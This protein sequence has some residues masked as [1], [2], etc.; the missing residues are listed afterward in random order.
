VFTG[1]GMSAESGISTFRDSNGLWDNHKVEDV[2]SI[3]A[4]HRNSTL[5]L[6]FYN[7]RRRQLL[8]VKPNKGHEALVEMEKRFPKLRVITQNVD[9]LHERAGQANVLHLHGQ[10]RTSRSTG[11]GEEVFSIE[12]SELSLGD[13]CPKGFQLRP[14]IVWFGEM[15]PAFEEALT[16]VSQCDL[17]I[18]VGTSLAV[19][20]AASLLDY[21]GEQTDIL[22]IDP[23]EPSFRGPKPIYHYP[24]KAAQGLMELARLLMS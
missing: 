2:A 10:L 22:L 19:Y 12:G 15:V 11:P 18:V 4:W 9:D 21:V 5:V 8:E 24:A 14:N 16:I 6:E 23:N 17:L 13:L 1:A 3:D 20:P 7:Q